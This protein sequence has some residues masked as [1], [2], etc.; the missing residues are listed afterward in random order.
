MRHNAYPEIQGQE[1]MRK[2]R[3]LL[4]IPLRE[5]HI[6]FGLPLSEASKIPPALESQIVQADDFFLSFPPS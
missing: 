1:R 5:R 2:R 6:L 4:R 3:L